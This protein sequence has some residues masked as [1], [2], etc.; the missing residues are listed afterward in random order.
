MR[1]EAAN[2]E[3][4]RARMFHRTMTRLLFLCKRVRP[5]IQTAISFMTTRVK[6][7]DEYDWKKLIRLLKYL[8]GMQFVRLTLSADRA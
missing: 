2:L 7:T 1:E 4:E 8:Q 6:K 3:E 5:D